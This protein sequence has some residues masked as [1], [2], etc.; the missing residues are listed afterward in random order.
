MA[1]NSGICPY[2]AG[3][4]FFN[5][6]ALPSAGESMKKLYCRQD[7]RSCARYK[8]RVGGDQVPDNLWPDGVTRKISARPTGSGNGR[9]PRRKPWKRS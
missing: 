5:T 7:Y 2:L 6:L 3:C 8:A 4:V 9:P 1:D